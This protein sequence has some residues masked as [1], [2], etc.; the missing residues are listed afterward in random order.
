MRFS[1]TA[2]R[3]L[4]FRAGGALPVAV[5]LAFLLVGGALAAG[6]APR[7]A[8][9]AG[10]TVHGRVTDYLGRPVSGIH[11]RLSR[12]AELLN[13]STG[14]DGRYR[15]SDT[16]RLTAGSSATA[17]SVELLPERYGGD[18]VQVLYRQILPRLR[19]PNIGAGSEDCQRDFAISDLPAS[20]SSS[21]M[22]REL[23][24]DLIELYVRSMNAWEL[25]EDLGFDLDPNGLLAIY[26]WCNQRALG[27]SRAE[28]NEPTDFAGFI[29]SR[30]D[31]SWET[32]K[33]W[34]VLGDATSLL[35]HG[36][37]PDNREYHEVGHYAHHQLFGEALPAHPD[38]IN[39]GGYY[40]NPSSADSWVEGFAEFYS[41][42]VAKHVDRDPTP[43]R[44]RLY[45]A[46][47]DIELDH[48]AWEWSGW[49]E[50]LAIAG[51]L[52]D[53]ED[54]DQD[55]QSRRPNRDLSVGAPELVR[56]SGGWLIQ[57]YATNRS[58]AAIRR[59][60]VAVELYDADGTMVY[61]TAA[62]VV[63]AELAA[64]KRG[65][66][67]LPIPSAVAFRDYEVTAGPLSLR[68]D[69]PIDLRPR[70]LLDALIAYDSD[71]PQGNGHIFDAFDLYDAL[72]TAFGGTDRDRD[73]VDDVDQV[74]I[75][76]GLFADVN[77]NRRF[78][79][80]GEEPRGL[81]SHPEYFN[82]EALTPRRDLPAPPEAEVVVDSGGIATDAVVHI[83][84]QGEDASRSYGYVTA[85]DDDGRMLIAAPPEDHQATITVIALADG[86]E[87][88]VAGRLD[89]SELWRLWNEH[90]GESLV[91][92][93]VEML[94]EGSS[95]V[96]TL[97]VGDDDHSSGALSMGSIELPPQLLVV[98]G[99]TGVGLIASYVVA[100]SYFANGSRRR[101]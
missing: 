66:Y 99:I 74:F 28:G 41:V 3:T 12:G 57:G 21:G 43:E 20:Y 100:Y 87:P 40:V 9:A 14:A 13:T 39:H 4:A 88:T 49:W 10:C 96:V 2:T 1:K 92:F 50:E 23:W 26:G 24:P 42:L 95:R 90:P 34:I 37:R 8:S 33:P 82:W 69:D 83:A 89:S 53:F 94:P 38:N 59:T 51:V 97:E 46:E 63:P 98:G 5:L 58:T 91:S 16:S 72:A 78:D 54:G 47:Y 48:S 60:E 36:G 85:L 81:T 86:Y 65:R 77:G 31:G 52:L 76:H 62:P 84:F 29:G 25:A 101:S 73:G 71:Q 32:D 64:G 27:C 45:G 70:Q 17:L 35:G 80:L 18:G 7:T 68:D 61:R 93:E 44:Y 22:P 19:A 67:V 15:F 30:A 11:M 56:V 79:G 6:T 75:A 55:Y